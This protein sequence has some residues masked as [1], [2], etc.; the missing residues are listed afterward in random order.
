MNEDVTANEQKTPADK[1]PIPQPATDGFPVGEEDMTSRVPGGEDQV[2][3][4]H[5]PE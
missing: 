2:K 3:E 1:S 4:E 5:P